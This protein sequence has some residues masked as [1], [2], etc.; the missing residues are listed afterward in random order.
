[1]A[2]HELLQGLIEAALA[3]SAAIVLVLAVRRPLRAAFGA[4]LAYK[5]WALVPSAALATLLPAAKAPPVA[6]AVREAVPLLVTAVAPQATTGAATPLPWALLLWGVGGVLVAGFFLRQQR[7]FVRGLG[8][9]TACGDGLYRA[10]GRAGLPAVL[11]AL[12]PRIVLPADYASRYSAEQQALLRRH[13][14]AH[15]DGGDMYANLIA[16]ALRCVFWFNPLVH[17]AARPFRHDQ[18][19]A[20][21][22]RV[23]A[24]A[25]QARRSY[26]EAMLLTQLA[27]Q[28]LPVGCHWGQS[29]PLKERIEMLTRPLPTL[30]RSLLGMALLAILL[31]GGAYASWA[32]QPALQSAD[33]PAP[34]APPPP[35]PAPMP[36]PPPAMDAGMLP[37]PPPP[38]PMAADERLPEGSIDA[39]SR[40]LNPPQYPAEAIKAGETGTVLLVV[41]IDDQGRVQGLRIDRSSGHDDLD[42][43][44]LAAAARWTF[45]P[46]VEHGKPVASR[47]RVPIAF[48][49]DGPAGSSQQ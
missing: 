11:G 6:L 23:L 42:R 46:A 2:G 38:P 1:M 21:D 12:R 40:Q 8:H 20:C 17:L 3:S 5:A 31:S 39:A 34:P 10:Q 33:T 13:E 43:A 26:G 28:T 35:P 27:A 22:A 29:H 15:I 25:P 45:Q 30:K 9:L 16:V 14:Q 44:A 18:E 24:R 48:A 37:P 32:S 49:L 4:R 19:L 36:P 47:V 41:A 7:R